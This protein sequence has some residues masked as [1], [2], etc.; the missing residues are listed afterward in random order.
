MGKQS[1]RKRERSPG[2]A[3][4]ARYLARAGLPDHPD[5]LAYRRLIAAE[6]DWYRQVT[7][8]DEAALTL[9]RQDDA[10]PAEVMAAMETRYRLVYRDLD[11][12]LAE[13]AARPVMIGAAWLR[14]WFDHHPPAARLLDAGCGPG[15]LTCAYGLARPEAEV[16]GIDAVPEALA[17]AEELA[18]R[19]GAH[20]VTFALG[21]LAD[22]AAGFGAGFDQVVAVTALADAGLYPH[23]PS[24]ARRAF[25]SVA[26][27][28]GPGLAFRSAGV[29]VLAGRLA[30]GGTLLA[31]DRTPDP[32][33]A[34]RFGAALLHAGVELDLGRSGVE[35]FV[36]QGEPTTFTRFVGVRA[37]G[38]PGPG[39][40]EAGEAALAAWLRRVPSPAYGVEWHDELRFQALK[41]AGARL[42]WGCEI[43]YT[44]R[45]SALER[46]EIW[47]LGSDVYGWVSTTPRHRQLVAGRTPEELWRENSSLA[48][49]LAAA[50]FEVRFYDAESG[51]GS[52]A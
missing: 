50:G 38:G 26:D 2:E 37:G 9:S 30:P 31:F 36:E 16:V 29:D 1:R 23:D 44:P 42:I 28:D 5:P 3:R 15:V 12:A 25:S 21:D 52:G 39:D 51:S 11:T 32:A 45:S 47:E 20:N 48:G 35:V 4:A 18:K 22:P 34:V 13:Y 17:C 27:V 43:D 24:E 41:S 19:V 40:G 49:Q 10:D 8:A 7:E 6:P 46:R 14:W 33:Q